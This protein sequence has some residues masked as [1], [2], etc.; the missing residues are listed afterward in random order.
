[1][2]FQ[3]KVAIVTG[4]GSGIGRGTARLFSAEGAKVVIADVVEERVQAAVA[5]IKASGGQATGVVM[6]LRKLEDIQ[7]MAA[8]ALDAF[9]R[10]D[11]LV[12]NAGI[13]FAGGLM[14]TSEE[15]W[16]RVME[17]NLTAAYRCCRAVVP[18]MIKSGG[19]KIVNV[20]SVD[21]PIGARPEAIAYASTKAGVVGFTKAASLDLIRHK[22]W[23]NCVCPGSVRTNITK[24][25]D[26]RRPHEPLTT[27]PLGYRAEPE[28]LGKAILF[29]ASHDADYMLGQAVVVDG[30]MTVPLP[31]R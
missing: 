1:M 23:V 18:A 21:G 19:G 5:D 8:I 4:S 10:I 6:D 11:I 28:D 30:G 26:G 16:A 2:R 27:V 7:R 9:G 15:Q 17:T 31:A 29:L 22:I 20:A 12:N 25:A 14:E 13:F 24:P 3:E